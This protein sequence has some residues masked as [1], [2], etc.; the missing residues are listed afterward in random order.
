MP[1]MRS[2]I[3]TSYK[4]QGLLM[5]A[6]G[7]F[8]LIVSISSSI[9]GLTTGLRDEVIATE[10]DFSPDE[11]DSY[12]TSL[13]PRD[14]DPVI[15]I[16]IRSR[17]TSQI[18][19][20]LNVYDHLGYP[21]H[22]S[23]LDTPWTKELDLSDHHGDYWK[24]GLNIIDDNVTIEDLDVTVYG[25]DPSYLKIGCIIGAVFF[26]I[27]IIL[28]ILGSIMYY[29]G[30][31]RMR[32]IITRRKDGSYSFENYHFSG[33]RKSLGLLYSKYPKERIIVDEMSGD[34]TPFFS[35]E[36]R[37][38][39][40]KTYPDYGDSPVMKRSPVEGKVDEKPKK[41][42]DSSKGPRLAPLPPD[43]SDVDD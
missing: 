12:V 27:A 20:E 23:F 41:R 37:R 36:Y 9:I 14:S 29:L 25:R 3:N 1:M 42:D 28:I 31:Y 5:L 32:R 10:S 16:E 30:K 17:S 21:L 39:G 40:K 2:G 34:K 35:F 38:D 11:G 26:L 6:L 33:D 13:E 43:L 19:V 7:I 8:I 22:T 18:T 15:T 24:I 4:F